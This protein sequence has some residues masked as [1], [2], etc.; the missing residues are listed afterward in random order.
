MPKKF[1]II[2]RYNKQ[3]EP[4]ENRPRFIF[5]FADKESTENAV[6]VTFEPDRFERISEYVKRATELIGMAVDGA[7]NY[8]DD[9]QRICMVEDLL[10]EI[11][12]EMEGD[13]E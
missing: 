3:Y 7:E 4:D 9:Y 8:G 5:A 1:K 12:R 2:L 11:T 13:A 10:E 6:N